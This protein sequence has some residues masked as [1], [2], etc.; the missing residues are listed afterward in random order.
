MKRQVERQMNEDLDDIPMSY[1]LYIGL[2]IVA[3]IAG[4]VIMIVRMFHH[5]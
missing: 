5:P 3:I 2:G 4:A 1:L